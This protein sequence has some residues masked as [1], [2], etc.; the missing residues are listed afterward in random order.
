M[1]TIYNILTLLCVLFLVACQAEDDLTTKST[2]YLSLKIVANNSTTTKAAD[3][4]PYNPKQ[5]AVQIL[6]ESGIVI[7]ETDDYTEWNNKKFELP[8]GKYTVKAASNGFDGLS[9]A[10]DK[11]Y[12]AGSSDVTV[13]SGL[14]VTANVTCTLAN[15]LVTVNF[16]TK[17]KEGF[18]SATIVVADSADMNG[19]RLTFQMGEN[20]TAKAYFP[21]PEKSLIVQTS[22]TNQKDKTYS[23]NDTVREVKARDNVKLNYKVSDSSEGSTSIDIQLDGSIKTYNFTI[24]VPVTAKT[25][26]SI[27]ANPWASFVYLE[28][29]ILSKVGNIDKSK[30]VL[31]YK[32]A[33][34]EEWTSVAELTEGAEDSYS[35]KV[36][37]LTPATEYQCRFVYKDTEE[38]SSEVIEFA[39]EAATPL[40]NGNFDA[41][42][43]IDIKG[44]LGNVKTA[45]PNASADIKFW[46]TSNSGA[47]SMSSENPTKGVTDPVHTSGGKAAE[48]QSK[49]VVIAFAAAS[50]YTGTF[51]EVNMGTMSA[52]LNFGQPFTSRPIE[53]KGFYRYIPVAID[54]VGKNL[55]SNTVQKGDP[56]QCSI[57]IALA[58]K[59]FLI[60]NND[61]N[62]FI[63]FKE[64]PDIIAYGELPSGVATEGLDY[65]EFSIPIKYK[66]LTEKPTHIIIVCSASKYGD[67]MTGGAGSKLYVDDFSLIYDGE[68]VLWK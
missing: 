54:N 30:L 28:G 19:T 15:V 41:W 42:C 67:Y 1:K 35:A 5:L 50:L 13:V 26:L 44:L 36:T 57:Y 34:A 61:P 68:P 62:T 60:D 38:V 55:P 64:D 48:L 39:T 9:A 63:N 29:K 45:Y 47:N 23:K 37:G 65:V 20:E 7:E 32:F 51:G 33:S 16:D 8:V 6:N 53:L 43:D 18:K 56:D 49:K 52:T 10:W 22:V 27:S 46:D 58:K 17:F 31:E 11:P 21:V 2:G 24:G 14:D 4:E 40:Q 3:E 12:Y 59:S 25:T 66:N